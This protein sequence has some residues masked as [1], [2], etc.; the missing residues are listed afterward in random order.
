MNWKLNLQY[1]NKNH[2]SFF[3]TDRSSIFFFFF[4]FQKC[5]QLQIN[6]LKSTFSINISNHKLKQLT[7]WSKKLFTIWN[8]QFENNQLCII[9]DLNKIKQKRWPNTC[10]QICCLYS[11]QDLQSLTC[12]LQRKQSQR[13]SL[14]LLNILRNLKV[15]N[16]I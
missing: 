11:H 14:E 5:D 12:R 9:F 16:I 1:F 6:H 13:E 15:N 10:H 4:Q 3:P 8:T 2:L 7:F